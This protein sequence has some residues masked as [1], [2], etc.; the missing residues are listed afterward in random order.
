MQRVY[1]NAVLS[2]VVSSS[3]SVLTWRR[4]LPRTSVARPWMLRHSRMACHLRSH[5]SG[6]HAL[7]HV[8]GG[9]VHHD[10]TVSLPRYSHSCARGHSLSVTTH[11]ARIGGRLWNPKLTLLLLL[12]ML[13]LGSEPHFYLMVLLQQP[14]PALCF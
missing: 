14:L 11:H 9:W 3:L 2:L 10:P 13:L 12:L 8:R 4:E 7:L 6:L 1:V 5:L